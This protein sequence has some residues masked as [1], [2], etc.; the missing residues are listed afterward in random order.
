MDEKLKNDAKKV[1]LVQ[2]AADGK[3]KAVTDVDKD[4]NIQTTD[5][6]RQNMANLLNVNTQ[7]SA[8]EAFFKK[9]MQEADNPS[10]TGIFIMVEN[11]LNKLIKIDF[12]P[13]I[14]ENYRVDPEQVLQVKQEGQRFEPMDT[15]KIDLTDLERKG[16]RME[17]LE[18][19]L[20]AMSYGHKS[21]G[22]IEMNPELEPGGIRFSTK[23]RVSL[24]PQ[25]DGTLRV[26]PHYWQEKPNLDA[27]FHGV[28]LADDVKTNITNTRHAGKVVNLELE[29]GKMTPCYVSCDK[30]TNTLEVM[31]VEL[32]E[33]RNR[34]KEADLSEGKQMDFYGGGKVL[35][36]GYITRA[37]YKRDAYIQVDA[38]ERNYEFTY[39][40][41]DRNRYAQ[42]NKEIYR[43]K[44]A[45]NKSQKQT[46][47]ED[48]K[49]TLTIHRKILNADVPSKAY[50]QWTE[51][52]KDP[53]KRQDVQAFYIK[54]MMKD[55]QGEP[56]NAW[57]KPN[58]E[59]NKMDFFKWN[60]NYSKKQ[61]AINSD[62]KTAEA[63]KGVKEPIKQG[64]QRPTA[65]Q[66][67]RTAQSK[68]KGVTM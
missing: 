68:S 47:P 2:H 51:A 44:I 67:R 62:G 60:P 10:H 25:P 7:D 55:G 28:L 19:H 46:A 50:D 32:L 5:P 12:D 49:T 56:F 34:I 64:Q 21:N 57:V 40:G 8:L 26:I 66:K 6:T 39:E 18:P 30:W 31:P 4:G 22:L 11:V 13:E 58:F 1:M 17:D 63:L 59:K 54:G 23:G 42:E 16:I 14:L 45:E 65:P 52:V 9:F 61:G 15:S 3:I 24:E 36:E 29:I 35:L 43:Q 33:K 27:P 38:A 37:G 53:S 48:T 41:L 20:K